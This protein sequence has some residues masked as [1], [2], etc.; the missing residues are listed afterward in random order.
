MCTLKSA[1]HER[2]LLLIQ[3]LGRI[4]RDRG[5][6]GTM[7]QAGKY[8]RKARDRWAADVFRFAS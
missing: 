4:G 6:Y 1:S 5:C 7:S 8:E 3:R 2:T